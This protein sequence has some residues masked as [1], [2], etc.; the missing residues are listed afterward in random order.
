MALDISKNAN[1]IV[2]FPTFVAS[3]M[4]QY[5]HVIN[6]VMKADTDNGTLAK[7]GAYVSFEQYEQAAVA[8][9]EVEVTVREAAAEKDCWYVEVTK[10]PA[11]LVFV[12]Y[13]DPLSPYSEKEL[14][15]E[16]LFY[17][18]TGDVT[19]GMELHIGDCFSLSNAAFT[20]TVAPGAVAKYTAGKYVI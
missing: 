13:N 5:G 7:K 1:H 3:A 16:R 15:D 8:A 10:L 20:G 14:R 19:Q 17:N 6:L 4:G 2:F 9:N 12:V 18:A 11:D